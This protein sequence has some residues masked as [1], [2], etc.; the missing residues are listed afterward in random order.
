MR[1]GGWQPDRHM[2]CSRY[3][4][5]LE[6]TARYLRESPCSVVYDVGA[7]DGRLAAG[8]SELGGSW[9]GFDRDPRDSGV[10]AWNVDEPCPRP[11]A[12]AGLV[13]L[14][15]VVEHL[16]NPQQAI[17]RIADAMRPGATLILTT[18]NPRWSWS[19]L[20]GLIHGVPACFTELDLRLNGHVFT[21]W[22]HILSCMLDQAGLVVEEYVTLDE[23]S[24]WP[25]RPYT[26]RYILRLGR[27][28][29]CRLIESMDPSACGMSY[30]MVA[31]KRA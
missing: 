13:L 9:I 10:A 15:D 16:G 28:L 31:R 29:C 2:Q 19:R 22:P 5:A 30:G 24:A 7:G 18:P 23:K 12:V 1:I 8:V 25:S 20:Y 14:L 17:A 21:A 11:G 26:A 4:F 3:E 6:M 27:A